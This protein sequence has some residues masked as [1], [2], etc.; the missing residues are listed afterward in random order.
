M[1]LDTRYIFNLTQW[2]CLIVFFDLNNLSLRELAYTFRPCQQ[3]TGEEVMPKHTLSDV[4]LQYLNTI[5]VTENTIG[6]ISSH[7]IFFHFFIIL[8]S[9]VYISNED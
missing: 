4:T 9:F 8:V 1:Q 5:T 2:L 7:L 3:T 6:E